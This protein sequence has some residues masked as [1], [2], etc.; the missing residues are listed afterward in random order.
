MKFSNK[1]SIILL[2]L[3]IWIFINYFTNYLNEKLN[4]FLKNPPKITHYETKGKIKY[5]GLVSIILNDE[6]EETRRR[7]F[8]DI[9]DASN[10]INYRL[11]IVLKEPNNPQNIIEELEFI[12]KSFNERAK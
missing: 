8:H 6:F 4:I 7:I 12:K 1:K 11:N 10:F 5:Q 9:S 3:L 2:L